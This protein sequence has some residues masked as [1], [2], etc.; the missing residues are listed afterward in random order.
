MKLKSI[1]YLLIVLVGL[2]GYYYLFV[3]TE[4]PEE[5]ETTIYAWE[6][7]MREIERV[8]IKLPRA[9]QETSFIR[10]PDDDKFPWYFDDEEQSLVDSARWGGGITLILSG[11][12]TKR[13]ISKDTSLEKLTEY[14]LIDPQMEIV[15]TIENGDALNITVGDS[16]PDN[17]AYYVQIPDTTD[18][19]LVDYSWYDVLEALVK[20]PPYASLETE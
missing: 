10:I 16:T 12:G 18:V 19:A 9:E 20:D 3:D 13:I 4:I 15:V 2:A 1:I 14:G 6:L 5:I 7:D 8:D 11:P 17:S